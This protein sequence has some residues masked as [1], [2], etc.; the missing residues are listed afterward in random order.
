MCR[1]IPLLV[2]VIFTSCNQAEVPASSPTLDWSYREVSVNSLDSL[3]PH[4]SYL[5]VYSQ[6]YSYSPETTFPLTATVSIHN[7]SL[8]DSIFITKA[9]YYN[10]H[11]ELIRNYINKPIFVKPLESL[12]IV[13]NETDGSGGTGANF[14]FDWLTQNEGNEPF[15]EAVMIST[16]GQQGMSF[17]T[18]G[19]RTK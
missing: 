11:G 8:S 9:D 6:I 10:T 7:T 15:F 17:T 19:V 13:I 4:S 1:I 14:V 12:Q 3:M 2:F 18:K 16:S 5:S